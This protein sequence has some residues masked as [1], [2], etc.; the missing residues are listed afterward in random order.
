VLVGGRAES[1]PVRSDQGYRGDLWLV[2]HGETEWSRSGRHTSDTDL[3][4]TSYG[5]RQAAA[6]RPLLRALDPAL[7]L[8]SPRYRSRRTAELAGLDGC[9]V[10]DDL[11][12]WNYGEY[13]GRTTPE[14]R[15]DRPGWTVWTGDPPGGETAAQVGARADRVLARIRIAL[16]DGAVVAVTHGHFGRVM[17]AR[18]LE[19]EPTG[20]RLFALDPAAPCVLGTEH[21]SPVVRRWNLPAPVSAAEA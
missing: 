14:I 6:L 8:I 12:E 2:R 4:L 17:A 9:E 21:G 15:A 1:G 5:E 20:G 16:A 10:D 18:W 3:P 7:V 19:L 11:A 13:E